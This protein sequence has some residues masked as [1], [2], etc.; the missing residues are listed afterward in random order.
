MDTPWGESQTVETVTDGILNISTA[1]HGGLWIS[2]ER[3]AEM[4]DIFKTPSKF[5]DGGQFFE[6]DCEWARVALSFP[7]YFP[8][9]QKIARQTFRYYHPELVPA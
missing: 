1:G 5:Y 8:D 7:K 3:L 6:E 4:P 9:S 2:C